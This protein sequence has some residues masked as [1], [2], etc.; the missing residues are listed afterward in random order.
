MDPTTAFLSGPG[1][2]VDTPSSTASN[3]CTGEMV[4][5][6]WNFQVGGDV[7]DC[8]TAIDINETTI[9]FSNSVSGRTI[10]NLSSKIR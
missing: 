5:D 4:D 3:N 6:L 1:S 2:I 8:D 10:R 9:L 7:R